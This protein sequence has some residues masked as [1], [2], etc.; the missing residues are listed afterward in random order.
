M[1][2]TLSEQK[3]P[4]EF[5][6]LNGEKSGDHEEKSGHIWRK[7]WSIGEKKYYFGVENG[8]DT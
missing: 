1:E 3:K 4:L 6:S 8:L 5:S 2:Q 7:K